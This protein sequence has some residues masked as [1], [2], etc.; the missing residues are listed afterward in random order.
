MQS[1]SR[2]DRDQYYTIR[3]GRCG[4]AFK[5]LLSELLGLRTF[6]CTEC[7]HRFAG[8]DP[9]VDW[10]RRLDVVEPIGA[11][12]AAQALLDFSQVA[13]QESRRQRLALVLQVPNL[14][15]QT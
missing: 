9:A 15:A 8:A 12:A 7:Q 1:A 14:A 2:V 6:D 10:L 4:G 3:C 13:T 11:S 5:I